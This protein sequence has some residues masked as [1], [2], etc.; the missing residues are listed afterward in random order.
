MYD[1]EIMKQRRKI[2]KERLDKQLAL[3]K[4]IT[5]DAEPDD[6]KRIQDF[7]NRLAWE[8]YYDALYTLDGSQMYERNIS[9]KIAEVA[10]GKWLGTDIVD[11]SFGD[12]KDYSVP[13]CSPAGYEIGVKCCRTTSAVP[14]VPA[15]PKYPEIICAFD[16]KNSKVYILGLAT[17]E[18]MKKYAD[19]KLNG[20]SIKPTYKK[21]FDRF[22]LL[23]PLSLELIE[24]Y[25]M[26]KSLD[27]VMKSATNK[28]QTTNSH[29]PEK[30]KTH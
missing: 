4:H 24:K 14:Y 19:E 8:K 23:Q 30:P 3:N 21:G 6:F 27:D 15:N 22:D 18:V 5:I 7:C 28:V 17:V 13:D 10:V 29:S 25:K 1:R 26:N 2:A 20:D 9:G 11:L 16:E 12:A